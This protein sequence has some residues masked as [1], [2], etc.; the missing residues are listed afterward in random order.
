[1][2]FFVFVTVC[3]MASSSPPVSSRKDDKI[4]WLDTQQII[5]SL[6]FRRRRGKRQEK[7]AKSLGCHSNSC[8]LCAHRRLAELKRQAYLVCRA[9]SQTSSLDP[10]RC[11][12]SHITYS[13]KE[14]IPANQRGE[15]ETPLIH[16]VLC[17][18]VLLGQTSEQSSTWCST[19]RNIVKHALNSKLV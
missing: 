17:K 12:M 15:S 16:K 11:C 18:Q 4:A 13:H 9:W 6:R 10:L 19:L 3:E 2:S 8:H 7:R 14:E 1:M 5:Q